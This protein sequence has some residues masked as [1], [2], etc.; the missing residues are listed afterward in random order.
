MT[1][2]LLRDRISRRAEAPVL[3]DAVLA[4]CEADYAQLQAWFRG[5]IP[6]GLPFSIYVVSGNFGA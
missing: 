3:A 2:R 6:G 1:M 5:T 4:T